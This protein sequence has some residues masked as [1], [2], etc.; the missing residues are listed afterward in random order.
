MIGQM[1]TF[2]RYE[3]DMA[4]SVCVCSVVKVLPVDVSFMVVVYRRR[5]QRISFY[6]KR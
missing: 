1:D 3:N 5:G 2:L 6:V 4:T